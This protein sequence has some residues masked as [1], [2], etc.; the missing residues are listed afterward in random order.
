METKTAEPNFLVNANY[1]TTK[2]D[3]DA[4]KL[5]TIRNK[6]KAEGDYLEFYAY[7]FKCQVKRNCGLAL[8]G[9]IT[10]PA[11][12][13]IDLSVLDFHCGVTWEER[14]SDV[15]VLGFDC[16][17]GGDYVPLATYGH[18]T[19]VRDYCTMKYVMKRLRNS[20]RGL[21]NLN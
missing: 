4:V 2:A 19:D 8:L 10:V 21:Y 3:L 13:N 1:V 12:Y 14:Y 5:T 15:T 18:S 16:N 11:S 20:A 17:H 6:I 7:G 9:Y